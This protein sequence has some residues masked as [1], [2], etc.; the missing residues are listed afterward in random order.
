[1]ENPATHLFLALFCFY[2]WKQKTAVLD[3]ALTTFRCLVYP[4]VRTFV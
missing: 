4:N 1:L 3:A 2:F